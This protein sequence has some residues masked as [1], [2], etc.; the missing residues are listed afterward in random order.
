MW[1]KKNAETCNRKKY[2]SNRKL[3]YSQNLHFESYVLNINS[4]F[5]RKDFCVFCRVGS[6]DCHVKVWDLET[7]N[8][9]NELNIGMSAI[10][11][12]AVTK[13]NTFLLVACC[14]N[15]IDVRSLATGT[16]IYRIREHKSLV[17]TPVLSSTTIRQVT[18]INEITQTTEMSKVLELI[19]MS[20][21]QKYWL[22]FAK[23][24]LQASQNLLIGL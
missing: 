6:K 4:F 2:V 20:F 22:L 18:L 3:E 11:H 21:M 24:F 10:S 16:S 15:T 13:D 9:L 5:S 23:S 17:R 12:L 1:K 8:W 14:D 19:A 7:F